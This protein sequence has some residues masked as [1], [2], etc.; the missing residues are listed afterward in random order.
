MRSGDKTRK[1]TNQRGFTLIEMMIACVVLLVGIVGVS[2]VFGV[3]ILQTS[4]QGDQ[5]TRT[6]EYAQDKME[7]LMALDYSDAQSDVTAPITAQTGGVG[8]TPGGSLSLSTPATGYVDYIDGNG[9]A[10]TTAANNTYTREWLITEDTTLN[11]K[12]I[13]VKVTAKVGVPN[14]T[15][16]SQKCSY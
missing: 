10:V 5:S 1:R 7:Q 3:A 12:T 13:T 8:L 4:Q 15:L 11:V 16:V 9:A 6:A 2:T 14:F